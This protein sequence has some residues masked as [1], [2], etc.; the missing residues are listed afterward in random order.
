M[1]ADLN[2]FVE[3]G[4]LDLSDVEDTYIDGG[5]IDDKL[6]AVNIGANAHAIL[7]DK[8]MFEKAGISVLAP[9]YTWEDLK[10]V[11]QQLADNL[12]EMVCMVFNHMQE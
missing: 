6:Y 10:D 9:G 8:A 3:N 4:A 11:A 1:L 2:S 12:G 7:L 5:K